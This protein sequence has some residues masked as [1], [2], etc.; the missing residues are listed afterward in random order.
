[1]KNLL[2][3]ILSIIIVLSFCLIFIGCQEESNDNQNENTIEGSTDNETIETDVEGIK[4]GRVYVL[5]FGTI[6]A[7][8]NSGSATIIKDG[9]TSRPYVSGESITEIGE[10]VLIWG[11]KTYSFTVRNKTPDAPI[12]EG[13]SDGTTV[14]FG[15]KLTPTFDKGVAFISKNGQ[16]GVPFEDGSDV[17]EVG[18]Y[19]LSV[20]YE[21]IVSTVN[22]KI[23][24]PRY[25][26]QITDEFLGGVIASDW[27]TS[28]T[29]LSLENQALK[30]QDRAD[31]N[32]YGIVS[33]YFK[34]IDLNVYP[35]LS[36]KTISLENCT[37]KYRL[38][39]NQYPTASD[40][41]LEVRA[42]G[43]G[44][45]YLDVKSYAEE[46]LLDLGECF[47]YL[48][49]AVEG[50]V[51]NQGNM[52]ATIEEIKSIDSIPKPNP[53]V[54]DYSSADGITSAGTLSMDGGELKFVSNNNSIK[55]YYDL[56]FAD[57]GNY[58]CFEFEAEQNYLD[59]GLVVAI[60]HSGQ[61]QKVEGDKFNFVEK[62]AA[63]GDRKNYKCYFAIDNNFKGINL[64]GAQVEIYLLY[65]QAKTIYP[66]TLE[67]V[68]FVEDYSSETGFS[69]SGEGSSMSLTQDG[70]A[71]TK[72][73][74]GV[75]VL[76]K[77]YELDFAKYGNCIKL[78]FESDG[79]VPD[80]GFCI[81]ILDKA[82][83]YHIKKDF[84]QFEKVETT[85]LDSGKVRY[86]CY[87][88]IGEASYTGEGKTNKDWS[89]T[90]HSSSTTYIKWNLMYGIEKTVYLRSISFVQSFD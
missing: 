42:Q 14:E 82:D 18:E 20:E 35:F 40:P 33:R 70:L 69:V 22:F 84:T 76:E 48:Q 4:D 56:P 65:G 21:E 78:V 46:N 6:S 7:R 89:D 32:G 23:I 5:E 34:G 36:F 53:I 30:I 67:V 27:R 41:V 3:I 28:D 44:M 87:F 62:T 63:V 88:T 15:E 39:I 38:S 80:S 71:L 24:L 37:V 75:A 60:R 54:E 50:L 64:Y 12:I 1:M 66:K 68:N 83:W 29:I 58:M 31:N 57:C 79:F 2:K 72:A 13:V 9:G 17:T 90:V 26:G 45:N 59:A 86:T 81:E 49:I 10:Y 47:L 51:E 52:S 11:E 85:S 61:E 16:E 8:F 19:T 77:Q 74:G 55:A 43:A 73:A 25:T